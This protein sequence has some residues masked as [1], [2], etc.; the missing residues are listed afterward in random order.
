MAV[1]VFVGGMEKEAPLI[2]RSNVGDRGS[3]KMRLGLFQSTA[4]A[5]YDQATLELLGFLLGAIRRDC[6]WHRPQSSAV[7]PRLACIHRAAGK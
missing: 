7:R 4:K 1:L 2:Y 6:L 5:F 3:S